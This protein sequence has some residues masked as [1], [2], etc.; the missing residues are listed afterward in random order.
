MNEMPKSIMTD[1]QPAENMISKASSV[2][3]PPES[4][5]IDSVEK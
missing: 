1:E 4:S 5:L 3:A 2:Q